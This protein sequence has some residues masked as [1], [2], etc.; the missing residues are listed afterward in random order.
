M[1]EKSRI[2]KRHGEI[3][4]LLE[5]KNV[6]TISDLCSSTG[7][8]ATTIRNDLTYLERQGLLR[9]TF[10]GAIQID[11]SQTNY[12]DIN[13]REKAHMFEKSSIAKYIVDNILQPD[14]TIIL[15]AG[16]SCAELAHEIAQRRIP[17]A[18]ITNSFRAAV[19]LLPA[20][21]IVELYML[22]GNY[23]PV[24][25]SLYDEFQTQVYQKLR[26]DMF[27]MGVDAIDSEQGITI[28][29]VVEVSLKQSMMNMASKTYALAD[30]S[31]FGR[32][33]MKCVCKATDIEG[34]ITDKKTDPQMVETLR[35]HGIN[36]FVAD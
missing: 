24:R 7:C 23:D 17:L 16:T 3:L 33:A 14:M 11:S 9:R 27:F 22:G 10:G 15:D 2:T 5:K 1:A 34:I 13:I 12:L 28:R 29:G 4:N 25:G 35:G 32:N 31:K 19:A 30:N 20:L 26:A 18:V 36:V 6:V 8:S 21:D